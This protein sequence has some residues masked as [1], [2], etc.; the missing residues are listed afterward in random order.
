MDQFRESFTE[1]ECEAELDQLFPHG[2]SGPD[3]CN[4]IAWDKMRPTGG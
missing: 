1:A 4:E 3:V 2:F